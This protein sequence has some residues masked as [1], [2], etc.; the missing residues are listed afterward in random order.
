M[1]RLSHLPKV[2]PL[3]MQNCDSN[4]GSLSLKT[5]C[6]T[7]KPSSHSALELDLPLHFVFS[8]PPPPLLLCLAPFSFLFPPAPLLPLPTSSP[9]P[10]PPFTHRLLLPLLPPPSTFFLFFFSLLP[11]SHPLSSVIEIHRASFIS[12]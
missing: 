5:S 3:E 9:Q 1:E 6:F 8:L 10:S 4:R 12:L 7:T 2:T 11:L